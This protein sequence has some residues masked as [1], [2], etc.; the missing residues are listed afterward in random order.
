MCIIYHSS[1]HQRKPPGIHL[2][3]AQFH[4]EE[5]DGALEGGTGTNRTLKTGK[6]ALIKVINLVYVLLTS[7]ESL[8]GCGLPEHAFV[9]V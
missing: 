5:E 6:K 2:H 8:A 9:R 7:V 3:G 1:L 4:H